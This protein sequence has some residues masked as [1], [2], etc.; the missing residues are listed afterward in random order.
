[1]KARPSRIYPRSK[2]STFGEFVRTI[3]GWKP[4]EE[5]LKDIRIPKRNEACFCES[6]KKYKKC[7]GRNG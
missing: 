2:F 6:D 4:Y 3:G 1:M 7:C 5:W